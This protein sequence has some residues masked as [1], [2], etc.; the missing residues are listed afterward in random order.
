MKK[1]TNENKIFF[2]QMK[3]VYLN[4]Y[5]LTVPVKRQSNKG[6]I[7]FKYFR[8]QCI[9]YSEIKDK[10]QRKILAISL[11]GYFSKNK[12]ASKAY[13][14]LNAF[15]ELPSNNANL[16]YP[17]IASIRTVFAY[18]PSQTFHHKAVK[19]HH[20]WIKFFHKRIETRAV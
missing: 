13:L 10:S 16:R 12:L 11:F 8:K 7:N 4:L 2:L 18:A 6:P 17:I 20:R 15:Y 9:S 14:S 19:Q 1:I 5:C 3:V